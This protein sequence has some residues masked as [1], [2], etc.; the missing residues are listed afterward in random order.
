MPPSPAN[1]ESFYIGVSWDVDAKKWHSE[2][3][4]G[5]QKIDGGLF[6][7]EQFAAENSDFIYV[8]YNMNIETSVE[9]EKL[10]FPN[11]FVTKKYAIRFRLHII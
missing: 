2:R 5:G 6:S 3:D 10:N 11:N 7:S 4:I 8:N 9:A 1:Y